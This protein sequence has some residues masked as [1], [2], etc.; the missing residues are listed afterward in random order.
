MSDIHVTHIDQLTK[1][2][3]PE[4]NCYDLPGGISLDGD[5]DFGTTSLSV[6]KCEDETKDCPMCHEPTKVTLCA[7]STDEYFCSIGHISKMDNMGE[8]E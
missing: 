5:I 6:P 3:N 7:N 4:T 2:F 8:W 1:Y